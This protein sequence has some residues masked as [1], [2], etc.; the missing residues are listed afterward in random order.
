MQK[1]THKC[2]NDL[3]KMKKKA[4]YGSSCYPGKAETGLTNISCPFCLLE[5]NGKY[6]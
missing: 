1:L 6:L 4:F 5:K 3:R 2:G